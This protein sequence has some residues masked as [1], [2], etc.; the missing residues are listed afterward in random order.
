M[1][2]DQVFRALQNCGAV[3][4]KSHF[5]LT[6][7]EIPPG[8]GIKRHF[9]SDTFIAKDRVFEYAREL[10]CLAQEIA[11]RHLMQTQNRPCDFV[12]GLEKGAI[13][14]AN[15]V[16]HHL[17]IS[18]HDH[19]RAGYAE[20]KP[21]GGF[22]IGR[23]FARNYTGRTVLIV[24]DIVVSGTSVRDAMEAVRENAGI[25]F[26]IWAICLRGDADTGGVPL[27]YLCKVDGAQM[28]AEEECPLCA[29]PKWGPT[30]VRTD[31]N[32]HGPEF[33]KRMNL[34]IPL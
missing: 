9:H 24:E 16:C 13:A 23:G 34:P 27:N 31:I 18:G 32:K 2:D 15:L 12:L 5:C 26:G 19:V 14:L 17:Q 6:P 33:F 22:T 30:S 8:S 11:D 7:K 1:T 25:P 3:N 29:D 28:W 4:I 20:A 10:Y 21:G